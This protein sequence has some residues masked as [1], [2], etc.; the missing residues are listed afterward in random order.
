[1]SGPVKLDAM[2]EAQQMLMMLAF[3]R[4]VM[5]PLEKELPTP[6]PRPHWLGRFYYD[7]FDKIGGW[8][9]NGPTDERVLGKVTDT[10][11]KK[12]DDEIDQNE[13]QLNNKINELCWYIELPNQPV[14]LH[15]VDVGCT[16][17]WEIRSFESENEEGEVITSGMR[18][19]WLPQ[20]GLSQVETYIDDFEGYIMNDSLYM[21]RFRA[22]NSTTDSQQYSTGHF[23]SVHLGD[24]C[25]GVIVNNWL[26]LTEM[27][28]EIHN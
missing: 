8:F 19:G 13:K 9:R 11:M 5:K 7:W 4:E 10:T 24:K 6:G 2:G 26:Y 15:R 12:I 16:C 1:M 23:R 18:L 17:V 3:M 21:K 27:S 22:H 25:N 28:M 20:D 14:T